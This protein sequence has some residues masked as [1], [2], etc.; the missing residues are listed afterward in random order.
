MIPVIDL[1]PYLAA[2]PTRS[3]ARAA[4]LGRA[5]QDVGFFVIVSHGMPQTLIVNRR[6]A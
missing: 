5:L 2:R 4:E 6:R 3:P 1:G